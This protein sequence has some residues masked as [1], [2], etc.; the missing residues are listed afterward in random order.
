[1]KQLFLS[2]I[3]LLSFS[4]N[5]STIALFKCQLLDGKKIEEVKAINSEWVKAVNKIN[6][7]KVTSQV[8]EAVV[9]PKMQTYMYIDTYEDTVHW[10]Q[11]RNEIKNGAI[12]EFTEQ[13]DEVSKCTSVSLYD[14][15]TS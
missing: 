11:I 4:V 15:E 6:E 7:N 13:F 10:G 9:S 14:A 1:M 12:E 3:L 8:L 2:T 5:A